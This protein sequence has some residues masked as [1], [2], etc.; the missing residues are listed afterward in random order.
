L[1]DEG[2]LK[3]GTSLEGFADQLQQIAGNEGGATNFPGTIY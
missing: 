1:Y 3:E 2:M